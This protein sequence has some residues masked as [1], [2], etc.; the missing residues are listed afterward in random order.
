MLEINSIRDWNAL[1]GRT[2]R[3]KKAAEQVAAQVDKVVLGQTRYST[4]VRHLQ[5]AMRSEFWQPA[6]ETLAMLALKPEVAATLLGLQPVYRLKDEGQRQLEDLHTLAQRVTVVGDQQISLHETDDGKLLL[7]NV[8]ALARD[9]NAMGAKTD[10]HEVSENLWNLMEPGNPVRLFADSLGSALAPTVAKLQPVARHPHSDNKVRQIG[11]IAYC[12]SADEVVKLQQT[13]QDWEANFQTFGHHGRTIR[14]CDDS[15]SEFA[16]GIRRACQDHQS[17]IGTTVVYLGRQEK[18]ALRQQMVERIVTSERFPEM[19]LSRQD[20][21]SMTLGMF[22]GVGPDG[23]R[24]GPTENRNFSTLLLQGSPSFQ[25]D[26]DMQ[27]RVLTA[28]HDGLRR[29]DGYQR[30]HDKSEPQTIS[31]PVDL[32]TQLQDEAPRKGISSPQFSGASDPPIENIVQSKVYYKDDMLKKSPSESWMAPSNERTVLDAEDEGVFR[33]A[34]PML[35]PSRYK[36]FLPISPTI[37]DGDIMVGAMQKKTSGIQARELPR[38]ILH[39]VAAGSQWGGEAKLLK[40]TTLSQAVMYAM[41]DIPDG[42][43]DATAKS[44]LSKLASDPQWV[45]DKVEKCMKAHW[46]VA[47]GYVE[48]RLTRAEALKG[49][50]E[51]LDASALDKWYGDT[52]RE[53]RDPARARLE[54]QAEVDR[55]L[56]EAEEMAR[57]RPGKKRIRVMTETAAKKLKDYALALTFRHE[58]LAVT[59]EAGGPA[60]G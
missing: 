60:R 22:G 56:R 57:L 25:A 1:P 44:I 53:Q 55:N 59:A 27:A 9:L 3:P 58:I 11:M 13:L 10:P 18:E 38:F 47:K 28:T 32:L 31:M 54:I 12:D 21:E 17:E 39:T 51:N 20:I 36:D 23:Y 35:L 43:M 24:S 34:S 4:R 42:D 30:L 45:Q 46:E 40:D 2:P 48:S 15:P 5:T 19:G 16:Q 6:P 29:L 33:T 7:V 49:S 14:I 8:D 41:F 37:R 50:L 26:H 52:P